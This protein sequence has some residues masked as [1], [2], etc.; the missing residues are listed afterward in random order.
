MRFKIAIISEAI[1]HPFDEGLKNIVLQLIRE[2]SIVAEV[3]CIT[4][5]YNNTKDINHIV[6]VPLGKI[7]LNKRLK[8]AITSF[9]PQAILYVPA[10]SHTF[11]SFLRARILKSLYPKAKVGLF[12]VQH[13]TFSFWQCKILPSLRPDTL[14][15]FSGEDKIFFEAQMMRTVIIQPA[16][17]VH[18]FIPVTKEQQKVLRNKYNIPS[19][20]KVV[21]HVGHIKQERNTRSLLQVQQLPNVQVVL[22]SSTTTIA[23]ERLKRDL[24]RNNIIIIDFYLDSVQEIYQLSDAYIFPVRNKIGAIDMPLSVLEAMACNLPVL[25]TPFG[26]LQKYFPEDE[27]IIYFHRDA[28]LIRLIP[29]VLEARA[30]N[31]SKVM[32]FGWDAIAAV[33]LKELS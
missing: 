3:L 2:L 7:F 5:S 14:F 13:S 28:D 32:Q 19:D 29:R 4:E 16:I 1:S 8:G 20:K 33:I 17:D 10:A 30:N 12:G 22:V 23:D 6:K 24:L 11:N 9:G 25:T 27:G 21:L 26:D 15:L 31:R 18:H